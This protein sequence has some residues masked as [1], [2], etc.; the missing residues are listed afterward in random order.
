[1]AVV[2]FV[3]LRQGES[4]TAEEIREWAK[5]PAHGLTGYRAPKRIEFRDSLPET[6]VGKVLRRVLIDQEKKKAAS[7]QG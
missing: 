7:Q 6:M 3:V 1:E 2:A 4:A 5:D